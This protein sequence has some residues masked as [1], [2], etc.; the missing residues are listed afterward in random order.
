MAE[1]FGVP[2]DNLTDTFMVPLQRA[3]DA[4]L[5]E[6]VACVVKS[7]NVGLMFMDNCKAVVIG[8]G[9]MGLVHCLLVPGSTGVDIN[10]DRVKW[11][12]DHGIDARTP[13][14]I[15]ADERFDRVFV[16]PG[17]QAAFDFALSLA[18][19]GARIVMFA[20][21]P[22]N[23]VLAV[24]QEAYFKDIEIVSSYSCGP[25]DTSQADAYIGGGAVYAEQVVSD[26]ISIDDLPQA[27]LQMKRGE[28][29]KP[30]VIF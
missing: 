17:S 3:I 12:K 6:P 7:V 14:E 18:K 20:P 11:A 15:N 29:L 19:P 26:F 25:D 2:A 27:Y 13:E 8:L 5:I 16:C 9:F 24:P 10:T 21:L 4:A 22:P 1:F 28:I 30:M 23:E